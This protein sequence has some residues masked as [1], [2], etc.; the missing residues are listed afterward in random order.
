MLNI[1]PIRSSQSLLTFS[2]ISSVGCSTRW[3]TGMKYSR[4]VCRV[5]MIIFVLRMT[6]RLTRINNYYRFLLSMD[7]G[8][9]SYY[10]VGF[11][12]HEDSILESILKMSNLHW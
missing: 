9:L 10:I 5:E 8:I 4:V 12:F 7:H 6:F 11:Q 2:E 3:Q 1:S